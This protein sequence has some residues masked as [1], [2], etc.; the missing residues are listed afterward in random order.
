MDFNDYQRF[1]G[2]IEDEGLTLAMNEVENEV[3]LKL[4][5]ALNELEK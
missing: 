1:L 2:C 4:E 5:D 3:P